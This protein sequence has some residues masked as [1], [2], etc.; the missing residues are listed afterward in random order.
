M[1]IF[2][3]LLQCSALVCVGAPAF[4]QITAQDVWDNQT[5][6]Y[7]SLG[8]TVAADIQAAGNTL[9]AA[10]IRMTYVLPM[11]VGSVY[12]D[13]PD[14]TMTENGD[15]TV[16]ISYPATAML[17]VGGDFNVDGETASVS[18]DLTL[19]LTD[20]VSVA[21]GTPG[22][23]TYVSEAG[24][25]D[26]ALGEPMITPDPGLGSFTVDAFVTVRDYTATSRVTVADM[27]TIT[28]DSKSGQSIYDVSYSDEYESSG[29]SVGVVETTS[30]V[31]TIALPRTPLDLLN[32]AAAF[33]DG[34]SFDIRSEA[35]GTQSQNIQASYGEVFSD[36]SQIVDTTIQSMLLDQSG[37]TLGSSATGI[38]L[39]VA[40]DMSIPFPVRVELASGAM[41]LHMPISASPDPQPIGFSI[42]LRDLIVNE[43]IWAL[44]DPAANF[45]R[46]PATMAFALSGEVTNE[47]NFFDFMSL[48]ALE[49]RF[50]SGDLPFKLQG[51]AMTGLDLRGLGV[52]VTG[53]GA[54]AFDN[55][56]TT[57]Y[58]G[59]PRPIGTG[60]VTV[61]GA[62][63]MMDKLTQLGWLSAEEIMGFRMG[64]AM[65]AN[66]TGEDMLT[67]SVEM[68]ADGQIIVNGQRMQ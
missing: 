32:L 34:L 38:M 62:N 66:P 24:L 9:T 40:K 61:T 22:D 27:V 65:I 28:T 25:I 30:S 11:G 46:D 33:R 48:P 41:T 26:V 60:T 3:R 57:T 35:T 59:L 15:G 4:A 13:S 8:L 39:D 50:M 18:V 44:A 7:E 36:Q 55:T 58:D 5:V 10:G 56:D 29:K 2:A 54:F 47:V 37:L 21:S 6:A 14:I 63:A 67:S 51:L 45:A 31:G 43:E 64:L 12:I 42:D 1:T 68:T 16:S 52:G 23:I 19:T 53:E 17:F 20:F 49:P